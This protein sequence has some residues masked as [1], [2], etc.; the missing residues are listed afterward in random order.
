[1][2]SRLVV[3]AILLTV[4]YSSSI[5]ASDKNEIKLSYGFSLIDYLNL[6]EYKTPGYGT[7]SLSY[8]RSVDKRIKIGAQVNSYFL[9]SES[10]GESSG[11]K[12]V[13]PII[14]PF[15][16]VDYLYITKPDFELYSSAMIGLPSA[17][18]RDWIK[19]IP[20]ITL[21]G[22]RKGSEHAFFGELGIGYAQV[23][24]AGYSFKF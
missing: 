9:M 19:I 21:I 5:F 12:T 13:H 2:K 18:L 10:S 24:S 16:K 3:L 20:H 8:S 6:I 7:F 22:F 15:L 4:V 14:I 17:G 11:K 23:I 1:M